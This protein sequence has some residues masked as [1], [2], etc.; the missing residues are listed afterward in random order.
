MLLAGEQFC[1]PYLATPTAVPVSWLV[2]AVI[3]CSTCSDSVT[4]PA[5]DSMSAC[6]LCRKARRSTARCAVD[7]RCGQASSTATATT[8]TMTAT[9]Q[10]GVRGTGHPDC[11]SGTRATPGRVGVLIAC[12]WRASAHPGQPGVDIGLGPRTQDPLHDV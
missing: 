7:G 9:S 4:P 12:S 5:H 2:P 1:A 6:M 3:A 8:A 10:R 11:R